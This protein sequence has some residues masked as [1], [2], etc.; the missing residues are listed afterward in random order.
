M[1]HAA[2]GRPTILLTGFSP[3]LTHARNVSA[4]LVRDIAAAARP[5]LPD[6]HVEV[7]VLP[8]DWREGPAALRALYDEL[9]PAIAIHF[10]VASKIKGFEIEMRAT[11]RTVDTEDAGG[12]KPSAGCVMDGGPA[13][14]AVS[15]PTRRILA[16]LRGLGLPA[17]LSRD[18]GGYICNTV[19]YE[20]LA[21]VDARQE[22]MRCG[23]IHVPATLTPTPEP[24]AETPPPIAWYDAVRGGLAIV[25]T[26]LAA[27]RPPR[28]RPRAVTLTLVA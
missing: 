7:R 1:S 5:Q 24:H 9:D 16:S 6:W 19:L 22:P 18:A 15:I 8:T 3:F 27:G 10:G 2:S 20:A 11:N 21:H 25:E 14:R 28:R 23:F 12:R 13:T 17:K 26:T 4:D